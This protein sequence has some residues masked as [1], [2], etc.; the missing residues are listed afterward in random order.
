MT[1]PRMPPIWVAR[2]LYEVPA[3]GGEGGG[4]VNLDVDWEGGGEAVDDGSGGR[5]D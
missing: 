5:V 2:R 1:P 3:A 4:G